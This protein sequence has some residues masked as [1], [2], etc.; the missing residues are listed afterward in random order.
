VVGVS[1][2]KKLIV[3]S[4][5]TKS[6]I[7]IIVVIFCASG[8]LLGQTGKL[9]WPDSPEKSYIEFVQCIY[10]PTDFGIK[11]SIWKKLKQKVS[12]INE[13]KKLIYSKGINISENGTLAFAEP[14]FSRIR[15][16]NT[17]K[18][19]IKTINKIGTEWLISPVDVE[20]DK[21]NNL[22]ISDSVLKKV[23]VLNEN[24]KLIYQYG[25]NDEFERPTGIAIN[26]DLKLIY[27]VDTIQNCV[28]VYNLLGERKNKF[29]KRGAN[30]GELNFPT[31]LCINKQGKVY[32]SDTFNFRIHVFS[33]EG[34]PLFTFGQAGQTLGS[35]AQPKGLS[36]D[37]QQNIYVVDT[38]FGCI[39]IF[40]S[41]G[42]LLLVVGKNG[43]KN[44]EFF[45]PVDISI[46]P[47]DYIY[48]SDCFNSRIQVLKLRTVN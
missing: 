9:T 18:N 40:N 37:S 27:I 17:E 25:I 16:F 38:V 32:V 21:K 45:L 23:F 48:I 31:Y 11:K 47:D 34:K 36:V 12:G 39:Q 1:Y 2:I 6:I 43:Q 44:G 29:G 20:F 46:T 35:F 8:S 24:Y 33:A 26:N 3:I 14:D 13:D 22:Y 41:N 15:V 7:L 28:F 10:N 19:N 42:E 4:R 5:L 30:L